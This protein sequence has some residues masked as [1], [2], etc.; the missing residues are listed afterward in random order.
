MRFSLVVA[1]VLAV[2]LIMPPQ[3]SAAPKRQAIDANYNACVELAKAK[4]WTISDLTDGGARRFVINCLK[5]GPQRASA[6]DQ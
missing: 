4:G 2:G 3:S 1:A 5:N 6:R